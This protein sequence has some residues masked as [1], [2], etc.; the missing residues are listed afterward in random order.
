MSLQRSNFA[1]DVLY[2]LMPKNKPR[3]IVPCTLALRARKLGN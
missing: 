3:A 2:E 1:L